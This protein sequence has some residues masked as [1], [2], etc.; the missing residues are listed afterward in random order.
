MTFK[1]PVIG[2]LVAFAFCGLFVTAFHAPA[3]HALPVATVAP[4]TAPRG[5]DLKRYVSERAARAALTAGD[6]RGVLLA[7]RVLVASARG[8]AETEA[9]RA[10]FPRAAVVDLA[11]LPGHDSRGLSA[12]FTALGTTVAGIAFGAL[13]LQFGGGARLLTLT[14]FGIATGLVVALTVDTLV[15]ALTGAF[16]PTA[17]IAALGASATAAAT[18]ALGRLAGPPGLAIAALLFVPLGQSAAGGA[19][20]ADL[21]PGFFGALADALP[22]G[23]TQTALR[24]AIYFDGAGTGVPLLVLAAWTAAGVALI[25][26]PERI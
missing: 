1:L 17:G 8:A 13:L 23:A 21:V 2:A 6:V 26:R 7:G 11:P 24:G 25:S 14:L 5:F 10:A 12:V 3:P 19:L 20:G 15:G 16:W 18:H 9:V 4:A 22:I